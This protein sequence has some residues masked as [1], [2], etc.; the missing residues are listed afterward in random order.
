MIDRPLITRVVL[1]NYKSI[2]ACDIQLGP[3][4]ILVGPNG[5][6]K[7]NF[8]D[9]LRFVADSLTRGLDQAVRE[10]GYADDILSRAASPGD[11]ELGIVLDVHL[12]ANTTGTYQFRLGVKSLGGYEVRYEACTVRREGSP[13]AYFSITRGG[14]LGSWG[15]VG[16]NQDLAPARVRDRLYL[17]N[18]SGLSVFRPV[19]EALT[20][21]VFY[22]LNPA[23]MR[24]PQ[25]PDRGDRLRSDGS[26][27][28]SVLRRML[29]ARAASKPR[30]D[31]YLRHISAGLSRV[32][33]VRVGSYETLRFWQAARGQRKGW[34][35]RAEQVSDGTLRGLGV[36]VA[37]FQT[38]T[39]EGASLSLIGIEE[40][41][42]ALHP[43]AAGVLLDALRDASATAQVIVTTHGADVLDDDDLT[44]QDLLAVVSSDGVTQIGPL[45]EVGRSALR[46]HLY[47]AGELMRMNQI[48]PEVRRG[49]PTDTEPAGTPTS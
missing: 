10:R 21:M 18:A 41:E 36:L 34:Q 26:N 28:A 27:V 11:D 29:E 1:K 19:Y 46:D 15:G 44:D 37:L 31:D 2:V 38:R 17:V 13:D 7:S 24:R 6:G 43:A 49:T 5:A 14:E 20:G 32:D 35:F 39:D 30:I 22:N 3:L 4:M 45:D 47:S 48:R 16:L 23:E 9:S 25:E 12:D 40:P 42:A 33:P 8:L